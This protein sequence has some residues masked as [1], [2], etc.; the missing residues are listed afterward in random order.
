MESSMVGNGL[1]ARIV[2]TRLMKPPDSHQ[3]DELNRREAQA[4]SASAKIGDQF[5]RLR[6]PSPRR[7][8]CSNAAIKYRHPVPAERI[9]RRKHGDLAAAIDL[10]PVGEC[11]CAGIEERH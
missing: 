9:K 7:A 10:A 11:S 2:E 3:D 6:G 1:D 5:S 8:L 4:E